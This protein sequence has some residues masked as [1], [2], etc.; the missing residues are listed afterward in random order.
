VVQILTIK[1]SKTKTVAVSAVNTTS[2]DK[3]AKVELITYPNNP[4]YCGLL[5]SPMPTL[6]VQKCYQRGE[7][8]A[9]EPF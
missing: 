9:S 5:Q 2:Y 3:M 8:H 7:N 4:I 6:S 1:H